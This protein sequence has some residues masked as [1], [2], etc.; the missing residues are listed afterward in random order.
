ME[1]GL[2]SSERGLL[3]V[4]NSDSPPFS[5][6]IKKTLSDKGDFEYFSWLPIE[7]DEPIPE[8]EKLQISKPQFK[9]L[10]TKIKKSFSV[11][12]GISFEQYKLN[13]IQSIKAR[14]KAKIAIKF[15]NPD[16]LELAEINILYHLVHSLAA[17]VRIESEEF[18]KFEFI[19]KVRAVCKAK[20]AEVGVA[21]DW[22][23]LEEYDLEAGW[24]E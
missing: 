16:N 23:D 4:R 20:E 8:L 7:E 3:E 9:V 19:S 17:G 2:V 11:S 24:P 21:K 18:A 15:E 14:A 22:S 10:K 6:K 5:G 13:V 12:Y 1:F